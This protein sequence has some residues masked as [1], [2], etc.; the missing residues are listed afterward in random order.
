MRKGGLQGIEVGDG[1]LCLGCGGEKGAR[2]GLHD[3]EPVVDVAR[4]I[5]MRLDGDA[6]ACTKESGADLGDLS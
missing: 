2:L 3:F 5:R 1:L 4:V 6:E